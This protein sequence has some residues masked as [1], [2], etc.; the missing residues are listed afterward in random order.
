MDMQFTWKKRLL[1]LPPLILGALILIFSSSFKQAPPQ[2]QK[3]APPKVV[4]IMKLQPR[5]IQPTAIGYGYIKPAQEWQLQ[6]ELAGTISWIADNLEN[7]GLIKKG[8]EIIKIDPTPY[9]LNKA[10]LQAQLDVIKLKDKT[11]R[12]SITI[13]ERDLTLQKEELQRNEQL[14]KTGSISSTARD[15]SERQY[16]NSQ[17]QLQT[18]KNNLQIN[19]AEKKVLLSQLSLVKLDIEKTIIRAPYDI[20]LTEVNVGLAQYINRGEPLLKADGLAA[21]EVHA[22]FPIGKMRPLRKASKATEN[23]Q[24]TH[25]ELSAA[26]ELQAMDRIISWSGIV[27]RTAGSLDIKTQ[28]QNI[29]VRIENPYQQ[30]TPGQ[31]PPLIR[32]TFVKVTLKAP[33]LK[34]QLLIPISAL[35]NNQVYTL[36]GENRLRIKPVQ[37][38]FM[39]EQ[40]VVIRGGLEAGEKI[41][42]SRLF[43]AI[44]GMKLK[45]KPDQQIATWFKEETGFSGSK[46]NKEGEL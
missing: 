5:K 35:H 31:R 41:I 3:M 44:E 2:K 18:L 37:V 27:D 42:L 30:A 46:K 20:R 29:I 24:D 36:D 43:P 10:Q 4:R 11:I 25:N 13:A 34:K 14:N 28:S 8:Q 1:W 19:Q 21:A 39:Q 16:L 38:D 33:V 22:Q 32:N 23:T 15:A 9:L 17:Q 7:G 26:V 45:P 40:I 6:A 12:S